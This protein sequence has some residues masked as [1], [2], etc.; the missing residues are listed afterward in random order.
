M[1]LSVQG[2]FE[3]PKVLYKDSVN[4]ARLSDQALQAY[5]RAAIDML[6]YASDYGFNTSD[7]SLLVDGQEIPIP[8]LASRPAELCEPNR[9]FRLKLLDDQATILASYSA[10]ANISQDE[11]VRR[12]L[13]FQN[14]IT[15]QALS[16]R[17]TFLH[18]GEMY[19]LTD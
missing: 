4:C 19:H 3:I 2:A 11:R 8:P 5:G 14:F 13:R 16:T 17:P 1:A 6:N 7:T 15:K 9:I 10:H 18:E 12:A